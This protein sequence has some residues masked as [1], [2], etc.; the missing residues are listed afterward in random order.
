[1][2]HNDRDL[3][4]QV[5]LRASEHFGIEP[6]IVEKDYYVTLLLREIVR[7]QPDIIFKGGTSLSKCYKII[8]RFSEDIDLNVDCPTH[9]TQGARVRLKENITAAIE[10]L[11]FQVANPDDIRSRRDYNR[12][13]IGY[14][15]MFG[16]GFLKPHLIAETAVYIRA[17]PTEQMSAGSIVYDYLIHAGLDELVEQ[18]ALQPFGVNV[19][20][21][22]RTFI[23]KVFAIGD[24]YLAGAVNE[25]SRHLY[26][27]YKLMDIV[28]IDR[29][30]AELMWQVRE[31]RK[32]HQNC[33]SAKEGVDLRELLGEIT[34][35][36]VYK[37][38][39][40]EITEALLFEKVDYTT[41]K[42][43]LQAIVDSS[44]WRV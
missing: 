35:K 21:A 27:L 12:Y 33:H 13:F 26:D 17:Y 16:T 44:L 43:A 15:A 6:G 5:V 18:Y 9:P 3:F 4:E 39:Y 29:D 36:D 22:A 31:E 30:L 7:R 10:S 25:H 23:D 32:P 20:L 42:Q 28:T 2:L 19:Q 41:V 1:M 14:P 38:D 40:E 8:K 11:G 37:R 24:Y 34:E